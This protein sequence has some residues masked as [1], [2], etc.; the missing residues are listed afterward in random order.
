MRDKNRIPK[1]L[2]TLESYWTLVPDWRFGQFMVNFLGS[3]DCDPFFYEDDE[4]EKKLKEY[5]DKLKS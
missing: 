1:F 4:M 2:K 5:F 3:L